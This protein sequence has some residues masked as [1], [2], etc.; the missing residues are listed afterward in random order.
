MYSIL[1]ANASAAPRRATPRRGFCFRSS[2]SV[3]AVRWA[4]QKAAPAPVRPTM[5][6]LMTKAEC[7]DVHGRGI[8]Q[9]RWRGLPRALARGP[10][11]LTARALL[12]S[13]AD[14]GTDCACEAGR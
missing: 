10:L 6:E 2:R 12:G 8:S 14:R 1:V 4:L 9:P 13:D 3:L 7:N 11:A 5:A